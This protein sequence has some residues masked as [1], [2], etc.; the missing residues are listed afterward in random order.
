[1]PE[2]APTYERLCGLAGGGDVAARFLSLYRPPPY[3]AGCSQVV[4]GGGARLI[5]N[6]DYSPATFD[7]VL[8]ASTWVR[9]V[10]AMLD[11]VWGALDGINDAGLVA[12]LAFGG[13]KV[14]GEGFGIPLLL[15][16]VL[17][18]CDT[19]AD[20]VSALM[21]LPS[22]MSYSVTLL[23]RDGE[24]ATVHL[25]PDRSADVTRS[26]VCT[27]HARA[28][29]WP[30]YAALTKSVERQAFLEASVLPLPS[31]DAAVDAFLRPPLHATKYRR[32]FGTLYTAIYDPHAR[33]VSLRW[34]RGLRLVASHDAFEPREVVVDLR[35][36]PAISLVQ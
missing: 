5:R 21:R 11:C 3:L 19:T 2:L 29:E 22:H 16:Y 32:G 34:P 27:N 13:R 33:S 4:W 36:A 28:V 17:E 15:R 24:H 30:D 9:P 12:S 20:A 1:M 7:G 23:D 25:A 6:Y 31:L 35:A 26:T 8:L 18:T 10:I 14:T